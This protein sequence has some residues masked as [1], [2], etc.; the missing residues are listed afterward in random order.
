MSFNQRGPVEEEKKS[1]LRADVV[2]NIYEDLDDMVD[3]DDPI[4]KMEMFY[5][6]PYTSDSTLEQIPDRAGQETAKFILENRLSKYSDIIKNDQLA[7]EE[8]KK[9]KQAQKDLIVGMQK[10]NI[11][12]SSILDE[13]PINIDSFLQ[14]GPNNLGND[15]SGFMRGFS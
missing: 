9:K 8:A 13:P 7:K 5:Q 1:S 14:S 4:L 11:G 12:G 6:I 15:Q 10:T 3:E 2:T